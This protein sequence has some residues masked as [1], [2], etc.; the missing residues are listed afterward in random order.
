MGKMFVVRGTAVGD[1]ASPRA[2]RSCASSFMD[3]SGNISTK[4]W[5]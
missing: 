4:V 3:T 2:A 5:I 1:E